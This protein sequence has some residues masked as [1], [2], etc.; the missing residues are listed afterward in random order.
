MNTDKYIYK[1]E[2][3]N[4]IMKNIIT[5]NEK[6]IR[7]LEDKLFVDINKNDLKQYKQYV[8]QLQNVIYSTDTY[9]LKYLHKK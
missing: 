2:H 5:N 3:S 6:L 1:L 9:Y 8:N 4:S 7:Q